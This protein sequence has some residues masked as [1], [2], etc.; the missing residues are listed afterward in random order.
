MTL[1][2]KVSVYPSIRLSI[3]PVIEIDCQGFPRRFCSA[4]PDWFAIEDQL[5]FSSSIKSLPKLSRLAKT[6]NKNREDLQIPGNGESSVRP[7]LTRMH[8]LGQGR[9][10]QARDVDSTPALTEHQAMPTVLVAEADR[11]LRDSY[12]E[13][14]S[15]LGFEIHTAVDGLECL[16][17]LRRFLP[18]VLVLDLELLWGGG[19]GVLAIM[20]DD[21][22][23]VRKRVILTSATA[24]THV[25]DRLAE[26]GLGALKNPFPLSDLLEC[27]APGSSNPTRSPSS[28][29]LCQG[30]LVVD[31]EPSIRLLL[32]RH[33]QQNGFQVFTASNGDEA[34]DRYCHH[35]D[36][37]A[38]VLLD[39]QMPGLDGPRTLDRIRA[40]NAE[41]P[42]CFMTDEP[43]RFEPGDLIKQGARHLLQ[44]PFSL[45]EVLR[46]VRN[47]I[48]RPAFE[49]QIS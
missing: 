2:R 41:I 4:L 23:L 18:D 46:V 45:D 7:K 44:K 9:L 10:L 25:L 13:F 34:L 31:D 40:H 5:R 32:D 48:N 33:L 8:A 21:A 29:T 22:R 42:V 38:V 6:Q 36:E 37:I 16:S 15:R 30:I 14:L 43:G 27:D 11:K 20:R 3:A 39:V 35:G 12:V 26:P 49:V 24:S 1:N 17:K 19:E 28:S 47:L